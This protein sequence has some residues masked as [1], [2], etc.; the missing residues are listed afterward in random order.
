MNNM[1]IYLYIVH[2][3]HILTHILHITYGIARLT[4]S[5]LTQYYVKVMYVIRSIYI[6][7]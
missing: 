4:Y 2:N 5:V 3:L 7:N 6:N 1:I